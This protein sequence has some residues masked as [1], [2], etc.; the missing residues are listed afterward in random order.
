MFDGCEVDA[1]TSD[2]SKSTRTEQV[3]SSE[4]SYEDDS[5]KGKHDFSDFEFRSPADV[6]GFLSGRR[7]TD[8]VATLQFNGA[9]TGTYNG[10]YFTITE[11]SIVNKVT[12]RMSL[13]FPSY[14]NP[15]IVTLL[16]TKDNAVITDS[17]IGLCLSVE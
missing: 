17:S 14:S 10:N 8:G 16:L 9:N 11:V 15:A 2:N 7:F 6:Y 5:R 1:D 4:R 12:A 3:S 13:V